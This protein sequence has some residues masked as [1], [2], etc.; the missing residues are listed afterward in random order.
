VDAVVGRLEEERA[1]AVARAGAEL[2][3][4]AERIVLLSKIDEKW[5]D[6]LYNMDQLR[7]II[8]MRRFAQEDP[9]LAYKRDATTFFRT[10]MEAIEEDVVSVVFRMVD[11]GIDES[12]MARR[13]RAT[14]YRKDEVGQFDMAPAAAAGGNGDGAEGAAQEKP[15]PVRVERKPGRNEPCW[16]G[17]GRKY[18][19]CHW[20]D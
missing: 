8:G 6:L 13:W 10:M 7:D 12:R 15:R 3:R 14:E 5:K 11:V 9:K 17:S 20:P 4:E 1:D 16:C 19:K 2:M 18:K